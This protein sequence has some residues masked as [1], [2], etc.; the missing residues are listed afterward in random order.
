MRFRP[1]TNERGFTLIE[2][3]VVVVIIGIL[4][5]IAI[6]VFVNQKARGY[7]TQVK[8]DVTNLAKQVEAAF[9]DGATTLTRSGDDLTDGTRTW[10]VTHTAGAGWNVHGSP[11]GYC[12]IGWSTAGGKYSPSDPLV[13]DSV[14]GGITPGAT[15]S[16]VATLPSDFLT[17]GSTPGGGN[18][19]AEL[20]VVS[21]W[22]N[23]V[24][25]WHYQYSGSDTGT[26]VTAEVTSWP[27]LN[28]TAPGQAIVRVTFSGTCAYYAAGFNLSAKVVI[29]VDA[30]TGKPTTEAGLNSSGSANFKASAGTCPATQDITVPLS[31]ISP[32]KGITLQG[33]FIRGLGDPD[34]PPG[35]T[36]TWWHPDSEQG[37]ARRANS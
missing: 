28:Q 4:A 1:S 25:T 34:T 30:T 18:P 23:G 17:G 3:L 6:P 37:Q 16:E 2:L 36:G 7:E 22:N 5:G 26:T 20:P 19:P 31:N 32:F 8:A 27:A 9:A 35:E 14:A 13:Y 11:A 10:P 21:Y 33:T 15:C 29:G 12:I 24:N